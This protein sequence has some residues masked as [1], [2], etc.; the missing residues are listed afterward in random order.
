MS[1]MDEWREF[2]RLMGTK[3][4]WALPDHQRLGALTGLWYSGQAAGADNQLLLIATS[5]YD[6]RQILVWLTPS[7]SEL[8]PSGERGE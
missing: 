3:E 6:R 2:F 1:F 5:E 8:E 4:F 7:P